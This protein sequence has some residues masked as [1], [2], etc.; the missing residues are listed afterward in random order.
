MRRALETTAESLEHEYGWERVNWRWGNHHKVLFRHYTRSEALSA[1]WR[2][3]YEYPGF[4]ATLSSAAGRTTTH[5]ASWR[6]VVDFSTVPP[7]GYGVYPGGQSG[8][9]F[10]ALYDA[11]IDS[12]LNFQ[13]YPLMRPALP[14]KIT[15]DHV[16]TRLTLRTSVR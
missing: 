16:A 5:S 8:N 6:M 7:T 12:Y 9:P 15:A 10:S 11:Q 2:G 3:P 13:Y 4:T 14:S 1:L